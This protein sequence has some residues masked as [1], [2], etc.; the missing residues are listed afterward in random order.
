M[1]DKEGW[2]SNGTHLLIIKLGQTLRT[3]GIAWGA[4]VG[5]ELTF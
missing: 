2:L 1:I 4:W 3:A 5:I